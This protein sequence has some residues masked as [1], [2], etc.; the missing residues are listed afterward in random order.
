[1]LFTKKQRDLLLKNPNIKKILNT[2]LEYTSEFK[3]SAVKK[4]E[5]G[6][7][8]ED[9]FKVAGIDL[10]WFE[11]GYARK[12]ITRWK[13][14]IDR[15]GKAALEIEQRGLG[16]TGRP[17]IKKFKSLSEEVAYLREENDFL[18]KIQALEL[19]SGKKKSF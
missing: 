9:I 15:R 10:S 12:S 2:N 19:K 16:S 6:S 17:G 11:K 5:S 8:C 14:T 4:Y 7:L 13:K 1:M 3:V 18:K